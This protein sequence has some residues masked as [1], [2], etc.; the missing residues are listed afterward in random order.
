MI[1]FLSSQLNLKVNKPHLPQKNMSNDSIDILIS[2]RNNQLS[3][4]ILNKLYSIEL[5]Y[6]I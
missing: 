4:Q 3:T 1:Y 2:S 6:T 5:Y